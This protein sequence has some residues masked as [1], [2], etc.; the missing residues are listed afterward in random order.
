MA[1]S[2]DLCPLSLRRRLQV[3][4]GENEEGVPVGGGDRVPAGV[5][6]KAEVA[7][8]Q[9]RVEEGSVTRAQILFAN[10]AV[11]RPGGYLSKCASTG[12]SF[13]WPGYFWRLPAN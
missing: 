7:R 12:M 2:A 10:Q 13:Q 3:S 8:D 5:I 6:V 4:V 1:E 11:N 9:R